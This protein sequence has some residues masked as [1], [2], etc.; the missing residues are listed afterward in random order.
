MGERWL[1]EGYKEIGKPGSGTY[2]SADGLK[3][4]RI[5]RGSI[6]GK[7]PPY[8]RHFHLER[9]NQVGKRITNNH[10]IIKWYGRNKIRNKRKNNEGRI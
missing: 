6:E 3:Q 10:I 4:F 9:Y 8:P 1:G 2:R 7:H 5:D